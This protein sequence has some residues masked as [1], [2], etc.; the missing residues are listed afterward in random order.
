MVDTAV[1]TGSPS[2]VVISLR[3]VTMPCPPA[4]RIFVA[5]PSQGSR[6]NRGAAVDLTMVDLA[7]GA[8]IVTTGRYDE[9]SSR[10]YT[11]DV[12]GSDEQ[13]WL[14]EVLRRA[15]EAD[16]FTVYPQ[17]WWHFDRDGWQQYPIGNRSF[18]ELEK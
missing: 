11:N 5:D 13:R 17:E 15:M 4:S 3:V 6:H 9:M 1:H 10:S 7:T 14:R 2:S 16:G 12:G 8:P 18:E